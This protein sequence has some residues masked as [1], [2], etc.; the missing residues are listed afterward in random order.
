[1]TE[2]MVF[3]EVRNDGLLPAR[4]FLEIVAVP[5]GREQSRSGSR[6]PPAEGRPGSGRR[7]TTRSGRPKSSRHSKEQAKYHTLLPAEASLPGTQTDGTFAIV[8]DG[9]P[10]TV[11][12]G[13]SCKL[14]HSRIRRA[15]LVY[16]YKLIY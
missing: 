10:V 12:P 8:G 15:L 7:P 6:P 11:P 2:A 5:D 9:L 16:Y 4:V 13:E 1:M 3:F 14:D